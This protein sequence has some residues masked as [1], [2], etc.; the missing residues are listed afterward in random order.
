MKKYLDSLIRGERNALPDRCL[1]ILLWLCSV[2]Y[3]AIVAVW[4]FLYKR[5]FLRT[6]KVVPRVISVGN[7]T[8]GGT[9]KTPCVLFLADALRRAGKRVSVLMKGYGDDEWRV[10][11]EKLKDIPVLVGRDRLRLARI[12]DQ[13]FHAD[14]VILDDGFQHRQIR[15]DLNILLIDALSPFGNGRLFPLGTLREGIGALRHADM[16]IITKADAGGKNLD[17]IAQTVLRYKG[18]RAV[19]EAR[20]R[21]VSLKDIRTGKD[22]GLTALGSRKVITVSALADK[23]YF[24]FMVERLGADIRGEIIL[25][26]HHHY[27]RGDVDRALS[28]AAHH[29]CDFIIT[30]EKDAVKL[31]S[32]LGAACA[33][34]ILVLEIAFEITRGMEN[35][36][37]RISG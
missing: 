36:H 21:P 11:R 23:R 7:I 22:H 29:G 16:V 6:Y 14:T 17:M 12:A 25:V 8:L 28:A 18:P 15:K 4:D 2:I 1:R 33:T 5:K 32:V 34:P 26:D 9:G 30:T 31:T 27:T 20:Y 10:M 13:E 24:T 19:L 3:G 35:L 37:A